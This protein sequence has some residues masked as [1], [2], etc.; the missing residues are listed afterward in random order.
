VKTCNI[1]PHATTMYPNFILWN[2]PWWKNWGYGT[3]YI[4]G[5]N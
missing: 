5:A 1:L 2:R 3:N 4:P